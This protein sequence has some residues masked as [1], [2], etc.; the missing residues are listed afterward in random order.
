MAPL[1]ATLRDTMRAALG[2][3]FICAAALRA[4]VTDTTTRPPQDSVIQRARELVADGRT[5][6]GRRLIDSVLNVTPPDSDLYAEALYWRGALA[7][8]A[9]DA[10]R[11]YR[12]L[13]VEAPL[14]TRAEDA[15]LQLAQL[16][17][18]RGDRYGA[19]EHLQRFML[20]YAN[21]PARPRVAVWLV[22]LLF[23]Q[24][25]QQVARACEALRT[26]REEIPADN[27]ELRNQLEFY[28][29]RCS[30]AE[31]AA[32]PVPD[33][34][35]PPSPAPAPRTPPRAK[36]ASA[37]YSVQVAAYDSPEPAI[38]MVRLLESRGI[39]ARVDGRVRPFRVR[40]G[41][42]ATRAEAAKAAAALKAQGMGG[43]VT[44]VP[45]P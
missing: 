11:D 24:G 31:I 13:L 41:R 8:T 2:L 6:D 45:K 27:A 38:R 14:S 32:Q 19:T 28:A 43:F 34:Q 20:S 44:L 5:A 21:H 29:P 17:Q 3:L 12:R 25:P 36:S 22:R 9:A 40:V 30:A 33:S 42:Y 16:E 18:A 39:E 7:T 10:E 26:G 1:T 15:L 37:F 35:P 4:Q 23:E